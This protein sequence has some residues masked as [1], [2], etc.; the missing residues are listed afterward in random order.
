MSTPAL[1]RAKRELGNEWTDEQAQTIARDVVYA[2][3]HDPEDPDALAR[4]LA[5][6]AGEA[7]VFEPE[8]EDPTARLA[9]WRA[10]V[11]ERRAYW[12]RV[13]DAARAAILGEDA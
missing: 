10:E 8:P 6:G 5:A 2:A 13:A 4:D 7:F 1:D 3:L 9:Y 12:R 11:D